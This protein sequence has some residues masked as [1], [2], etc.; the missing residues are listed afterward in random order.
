MHKITRRLPLSVS[1][2]ALVVALGSLG[3][4]AYA[5]GLIDGKTIKKGTIQ[6]SKLTPGA[7][8]ALKGSTGPAGPQGLQGPQGP[9]GPSGAAGS[10]GV[11]N[12][13]IAG[14]AGAGVTPLTF[15]PYAYSALD[16][17]QNCSVAGNGNWATQN[18]NVTYVVTPTVLGLFNVVVLRSGSFVTNTGLLAPVS[19][20]PNASVHS[21]GASN[22]TAG[23]AGDRVVN[24]VTGRFW[25]DSIFID[26]SGRFDFTQTCPAGCSVAQFFNT[27]F[28]NNPFSLPSFVRADQYHYRTVS[29]G[30]WDFS[31]V[32]GVPSAG[33]IQ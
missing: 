1:V 22:C 10:N 5:A 25:G 7:V 27:F 23:P 19:T 14:P 24:G 6:V 21:P 32:P 29:N 8:K 30:N 11:G 12:P 9:I 15:G 4:G 13:G 20:N 3:G 2:L 16:G 26:V 18:G 31:N 33:D 17:N 28:G